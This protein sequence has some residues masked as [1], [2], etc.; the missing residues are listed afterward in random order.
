LWLCLVFEVDEEAGRLTPQPC[1]CH[2]IRF[3]TLAARH[4]GE[5]L[6]IKKEE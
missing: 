6:F 5:R 4:I 2:Q 3:V 1:L